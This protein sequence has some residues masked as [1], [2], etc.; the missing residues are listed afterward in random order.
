MLNGD[1][2]MCDILKEVYSEVL[3]E[4]FEYG[5][6]NQRIKLQKVV[7]LL[8]NMGIHVGDYSFTWNKYGPYS[9][10][11]DDDAY[12]CSQNS[13]KRSIV[14][15]EEAMK[16]FEMIRD[17][18]SQRTEY[19][20]YNWLECIASL[21]YLKYVLHVSDDSKVLRRLAEEKKYLNSAKEN[22]N[23]MSIANK[24]GMSI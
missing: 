5:E 22:A 6:L 17:I 12:R 1:D 11:L 9:I 23:A 2:S 18:V 14:F 4:Q 13:E 3:K 10:A 24:I 20:D 8:E 16:A 21:H 7:Y 19:E 15:T